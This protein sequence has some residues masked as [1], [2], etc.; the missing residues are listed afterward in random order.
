MGY[1][2]NAAWAFIVSGISIQYTPLIVHLMN[3]Y[4]AEA[5]I[6]HLVNA[7]E[8]LIVHLV[9]ADWALQYINKA[10]AATSCM[11]TPWTSFMMT[12]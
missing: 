4:P 12:S 6:L 11:Q 10:R 2:E 5:L 8:A 1:P 9:N 3:A 7:T